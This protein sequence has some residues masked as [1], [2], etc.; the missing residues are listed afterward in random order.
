ME[1][2]ISFSSLIYWLIDYISF[3]KVDYYPWMGR[4]MKRIPYDATLNYELFFCSRRI[5]RHPV[6]IAMTR[7]GTCW[8]LW[9]I[10][11]RMK[12]FR[13]SIVWFRGV[14]WLLYFLTCCY[15]LMKLRFEWWMVLNWC[16]FYASIA[17]VDESV[18]T[19]VY[20]PLK[21]SGMSAR[22][23]G[24]REDRRTQPCF[25]YLWA[26]FARAA[27][28]SLLPSLNNNIFIYCVDI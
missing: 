1:K 17:A 14:S 23:G 27:K 24:G 25:F 10:P 5:L 8:I 18:P 4:T 6:S 11:K 12:E 19:C 2:V 13:H 28:N 21:S 20:P 3:C 9:S 16:F 7:H 22:K 26:F 15:C